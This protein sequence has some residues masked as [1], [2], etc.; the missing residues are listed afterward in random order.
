MISQALFTDIPV[1]VRLI[2]SAYRGEASKQGWTTEAAL[3][4]GELRTDEETLNQMMKAGCFLKYTKEGELQG[5]VYLEKQDEKLYLGMLSVSPRLQAQGIGKK[6]LAASEDH[7][8]E[9]KCNTVIMNVISVRHE[10]IFWYERHGYKPTGKVTPFPSD[11]K[12]G[13]PITSLEFVELE[14]FLG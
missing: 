14:K 3:L 5:C 10:L 13:T 12:F 9:K 6:L 1:L 8:I 11:N 4:R 7:A 2:N